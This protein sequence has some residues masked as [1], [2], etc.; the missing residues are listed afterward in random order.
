MRDLLRKD[1]GHLEKC[2]KMMG[3]YCHPVQIGSGLVFGTIGIGITAVG[4]L[5]ADGMNFVIHN[6]PAYIAQGNH[7]N[8]ID[9]I[10]DS[11]KGSMAQAIEAGWK[12]LPFSYCAGHYVGGKLREKLTAPFRRR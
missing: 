5:Y 12:Q 9:Y 2:R 6:L 8:A 1:E 7:T 11:Y 4:V 10:R 3:K